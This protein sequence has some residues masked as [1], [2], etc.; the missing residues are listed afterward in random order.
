MVTWCV[1]REQAK[2]Q[3]RLWKSDTLHKF[4]MTVSPLCA[5]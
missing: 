5:E 4:K 3:W 2:P 1:G